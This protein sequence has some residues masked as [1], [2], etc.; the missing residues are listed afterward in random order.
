M[1]KITF[2]TFCNDKPQWLYMRNEL[3]TNELDAINIVRCDTALAS[4]CGAIRG[5]L[6]ANMRLAFAV[7]ETC[8]NSGQVDTLGDSF[9]TAFTTY[10]RQGTRP[11]SGAMFYRD[12]VRFSAYPKLGRVGHSWW[13]G[14]LDAGDIIELENVGRGSRVARDLAAILNDGAFAYGSTLFSNAVMFNPVGTFET[15]YAETSHYTDSHS[16]TRWRHR[17][18]GALL[19]AGLTIFE[20]LELM[21]TALEAAYYWLSLQI[22]I[23]P[24]NVWDS[25]VAALAIG[26]NVN[27]MVKA[28]HEAGKDPN[29]ENAPAPRLRWGVT[30]EPIMESWQFAEKV[31]GDNLPD[32]IQSFPPHTEAGDKYIDSDYLQ[33]YVDT[34][35]D[36]L[37]RVSKT[38]NA[39][40]FNPK[41][42]KDQLTAAEM[43]RGP[44]ILE[45]A[46]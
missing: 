24:G 45:L 3:F 39:D 11:V 2:Y 14:C 27:S 19:D 25:M 42:Y 12:V 7:I 37:K 40:W 33:H 35:C 16:Q 46:F 36:V 30:W 38:A 43:K 1:K 26:A 15:P 32:L 22:R 21:Y 18:K 29:D 13:R 41:S 44:D 8:D 20:A 28:A 5:I 6:K 10:N 34:L 17:V 31:A 23:A 4:A 9:G